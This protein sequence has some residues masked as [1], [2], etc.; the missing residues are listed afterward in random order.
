MLSSHLI[1]KR[2]EA[3]GVDAATV[4]RDYVLA[5]VVAQLHHVVA[6]DEVRLVFKGGTA[7]R[8]IHF[9]A[10]RYSADLDFTI[11][12]ASKSEGVTR[13][14]PAIEA[15]R[16][17]AEL[18][19]LELVAGSPTMLHYIG[20]LKATKPR[21]IKIDVADDEV[22]DSI[23]R[24]TLR[25][26][27]SDLPEALSFDA[28]PLTEIGAEKL[29]CIMQRMQ[30]RDLYDVYRMVD[31]AGVELQYLKPLFDR[32]AIAKGLDPS[33]FPVRFEDRLK[34]YARRW[35]TEMGEHSANPPEFED[36]VRIVRRHLRASG[37][38]PK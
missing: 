36:V 6:D 32:K 11:I 35:D 10:Y 27:W 33:D 26:T 24:A 5:H 30:C 14:L 9:D 7:L 25:S 38:L 12:G 31:E 17:Q 13:L 19:H 3:D 22:V 21:R 1:T 8:M 28:Y 16:A 2:A 37:Y 4:D 15:A 18:P 34:K 20:P 23:T 29:R